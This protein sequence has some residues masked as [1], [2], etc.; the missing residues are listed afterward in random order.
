MALTLG[1]LYLLLLLVLCIPVENLSFKKIVFLFLYLLL[2]GV[3]IF[4]NRTELKDYNNYIDIYNH[5]TDEVGMEPS[6]KLI[7]NFVKNCLGDNVFFLFAIYALLAVSIKFIAIKQ[8][9]DLWFLSILIY[10]SYFFTLHDLIQIRAGVASGILLL[11]LKPLYER[12]FWVFFSLAC[13]ATFFHISSL[14][15][16]LF[17]FLNP[18]KLKFYFWI[19]IIPIA[20]ILQF[21]QINFSS[22]L[23]LLPIKFVQMKLIGYWQ[24]KE[25]GLFEE[26]NILSM[27]ILIRCVICYVLIWKYKI[28][29]SCNKYFLLL[30]KIYILGSFLLVFF[31]DFL[32]LAARLSELLFIVEIILIPMLIYLF[33][34]KRMSM[35][36]PIVFS[37]WLL[38]RSISI[39]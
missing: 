1:G 21:L 33:R 10:L 36:F 12:K 19:S 16:F 23:L 3:A 38:F 14:I 24:T 30:L 26:L 28:L 2:L 31:S 4:S 39:M 22:F 6:F 17:W 13:L 11:T 37:G 8:L 15:I 20:Y 32:V 29:Y 27:G 25:M 18:Y 35:V 5:V 9:T 7:S 34:Q